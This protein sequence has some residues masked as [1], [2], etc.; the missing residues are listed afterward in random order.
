[1]ASSPLLYVSDEILESLQNGIED[2]LDRYQ[3]GDFCDL[4]AEY[5][6]AAQLRT[7]TV[8]ADL[9]STLEG[10]PTTP[11]SE[12][13]NSLIV[14]RALEGMSRAVAREERIWVRLTHVECLGYSRS[15]WLRGKG[16]T[17]EHVA[18]HFFAGTLT[19]VRD[20][21][22]VGRLWWNGEIARIACPEDPERGLKAILRSADTRSNFVERA[23]I[24]SRPVLA[25]AIV[26]ALEQDPWLS[27]AEEHFRLFMRALNRNGGGILFEVLPAAQVDDVIR[28]CSEQAQAVM[29]RSA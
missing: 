22:A 6:W 16:D 2:N 27:A 25:Q 5:G 1:M 11:E 29:Q 15:R 19:K 17:K 18:T 24:A 28:A 21:N 26:R 20:D 14:H 10:G 23:R 8:D 4:A 3:T 13:R 12:I 9:L 7:V